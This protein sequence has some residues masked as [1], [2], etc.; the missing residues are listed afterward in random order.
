[1]ISNP[2][3]DVDDE[4]QGDA[5]SSGPEEGSVR[6][7]GEER[8]DLGARHRKVAALLNQ[9]ATAARSFLLYDARNDAIR[10]S[11]VLLLEGFEDALRGEQAIHLDVRPFEIEL[12]GVRVY[13]NRDRERSLA[14]RLYR[15]GIRTLV[16][17]D[18][19][20]GLELARLLEILS[21]RY[22]GIHQHEDDTVTL[23][24]KA[25]FRFLEVVAV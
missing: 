22:T 5:A 19:F 7:T 14:F 11:L 18:G 25:G 4:A 17:R 23:L 10:R 1:M 21:V 12:E 13:L 6:Q 24:W 20:G 16:F 9:L 2:A 3:D 8:E 15:D